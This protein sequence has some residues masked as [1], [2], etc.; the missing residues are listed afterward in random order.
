MYFEFWID[1]SRR[2][3]VI[4]KLKTVCKE[5]WE[6]SGNYDLIVCAESEDQIKVDG[7]LNWR[8]HYTC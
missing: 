2:E 5:V 6:V 8:R 1:N 4:K 3:E 7:V